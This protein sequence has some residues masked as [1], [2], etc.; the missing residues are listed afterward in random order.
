MIEMKQILKKQ[1]FI[2]LGW[3]FVVLGIIGV[4]LPILPTTPFLIV[5]LW[6][7]SKSSPRFHRMLLDNS[8]VGPP[9]R[10]WE[11]TKTVSRKTKYRATTLI[12]LTFSVSIALFA[13]DARI[14]LILITVAAVLLFSIWRIKE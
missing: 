5:S 10:S 3:F 4:F 13:H 7:F 11:E 8:I 2:A 6:L 1:A 14:Q 12:V 9:L